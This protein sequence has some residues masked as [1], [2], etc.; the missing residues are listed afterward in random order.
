MLPDSI[1]DRALTLV[2]RTRRANRSKDIASPGIVERPA[3]IGRPVR[4]VNVRIATS[5]VCGFRS[6]PFCII[7]Q[8]PTSQWPPS[9]GACIR[10]QL[11]SRHDGAVS[12]VN[13]VASH[14]DY[15]P[16]T[17]PFPREKPC[18]AAFKRTRRQASRRFIQ[19]PGRLVASTCA[20]PT[21][22]PRWPFGFAAWSA[23]A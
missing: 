4:P 22:P 2:A 20:A 23:T 16:T 5:C 7:W 12:G 21:T 10:L 3:A 19:K 6:A 17:L 13:V 8:S 14:A 1:G 15:R 11:T 9:H 18:V